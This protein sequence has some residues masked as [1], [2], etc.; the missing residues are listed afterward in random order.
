MRQLSLTA[1][2]AFVS[3]ILSYGISVPDIS[4]NLLAAASAA[5]GQYTGSLVAKS[6]ASALTKGLTSIAFLLGTGAAF[7]TYLPIVERGSA[8]VG[9]VVLLAIDLMAGFFCLSCLL[10]I[11][12]IRIE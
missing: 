1:V 6:S 7:L 3:F 4:F 12:G 10:A 2:F 11:T 5:C 8:D 9:V